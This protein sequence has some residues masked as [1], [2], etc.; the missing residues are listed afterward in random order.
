M[1]A[2]GITIDVDRVVVLVVGIR[3]IR[4]R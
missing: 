3:S 4:V 1:L 2:G